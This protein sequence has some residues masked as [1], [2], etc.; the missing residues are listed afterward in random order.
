MGKV[1]FV[2]PGQGS[3]SVG[4]GKDF[5]ELSEEVKTTFQTADQV[6]DFSLS[7][8]IF[9]G[10]QEDLTLTYHAQP[11]LLTT[12]IGMLR[13]F[14][15]HHIKPDFVA[16][17]SLG[18]YSALVAANV[19]SFEDAV[20]AVY[21]RGRY[22]DEAVPAG[23]G[24]M[25]A[26]LGMTAEELK[27]V[28][29]EISAQGDEVQL[30]NI[31]CPGQIVISGTVTGVEKASALAKEKGAKR[32]IPLVV[33]G[34]F[35]SMLMKPAAK[36]LD[37]TLSTMTFRDADVPI[38]ANVTAQ[39]VTNKDEIKEKLVEQLYSPVRWQESVELLVEQ[40]VDTFIEIGPGKVLS[41]L[42]KKVNRRATVHSVYDVAS[43]EATIQALKG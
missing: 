8:I 32:A 22:M 25:A 2:F 31:N 13:E 39:P 36:Q 24:T 42:V 26:V 15:K 19:L 5:Y 9:E 6:L 21:K 30:A 23:Q 33:S 14:G 28:T 35:H 7:T 16:G 4:M 41:G 29:D 10:P 37:D 18:E 34:P 43:L 17:H 20:M 3:Q 11:A 1:A 12:S 38:V 27:K 40:G